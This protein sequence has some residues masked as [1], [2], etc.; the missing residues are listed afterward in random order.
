M[1]LVRPPAWGAVAAAAA[2]LVA[3][4]QTCGRD[5]DRLGLC[6]RL[7]H[8]QDCQDPGQEAWAAALLLSTAHLRATLE[9]PILLPP[10]CA[11]ALAAATTVRCWCGGFPFLLSAAVLSGCCVGV[12]AV[13]FRRCLVSIRWPAPTLQVYIAV[14]VILYQKK[15]LLRETPTGTV[16]V[17]LRPPDQEVY[18]H[19]I[20][21]MAGLNYCTGGKREAG[22]ITAQQ[23][24][25]FRDEF[26][27]AYPVVE[28]N[29]KFIATR[30][31][32]FHQNMPATCDP[33]TRD[34]PVCARWKPS[35][36]HKP[37]KTFY[38]AQLENFT[39]KVSLPCH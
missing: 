31:S 22:Q 20:T 28:H 3:T 8:D 15:Y 10:P 9:A 33:V 24:C 6:T 37:D 25:E 14:Y 32:Q 29:A 7:Q 2:A 23:P 1:Q 38:I 5:G 36:G 26:F 27:V 21:H 12:G 13:V 19:N 39:L 18:G 30:V 16:R 4:I 11:S 35:L 34:T 17:S